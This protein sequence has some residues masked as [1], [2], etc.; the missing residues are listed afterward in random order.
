MA[1]AVAVI[2][3]IGRRP[4]RTTQNAT[5]PRV[6]ITARKPTIS[7]LRPA[8]GVVDVL[9]RG[10]VHDRAPLAAVAAHL[11][12]VAHLGM[13]HAHREGGAAVVGPGGGHAQVGGPGIAPG[14]LGFEHHPQAVVDD[15]RHPQR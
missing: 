9:Q 11:H 12:P 2:W 15:H 8:D 14:E 6:P 13:E 1:V 5:R 7:L 10:G 4:R 3:R